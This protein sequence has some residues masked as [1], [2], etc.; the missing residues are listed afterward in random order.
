[1]SVKQCWPFRKTH[2]RKVSSHLHILRF[3]LSCRGEWSLW[4]VNTYSAVMH[5][6]IT[7]I[8]REET[9]ATLKVKYFEV[10]APCTIAMHVV[11][12]VT[13]HK[14]IH[15]SEHYYKMTFVDYY[16]ETT[17]DFLQMSQGLATNVHTVAPS[18]NKGPTS[19]S[20]YFCVFS[21][22]EYCSS[23]TS[24]WWWI[25]YSPQS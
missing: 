4:E 9:I 19:C 15:E 25:T 20:S 18:N 14:E 11:P 12:Q 10:L 24:R 6:Y 8:R 5:W 23:R 16:T 2:L 13:A 22:H 21:P 7:K 17:D 3:A 1:M